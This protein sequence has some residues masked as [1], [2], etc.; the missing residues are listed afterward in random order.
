MGQ[1]AIKDTGYANTSA[2][3][4]QETITNSG[5]AVTFNGAKLTYSR[6][7]SL[8]N[9]PNPSRYEDSE[10][11]YITQLNPTLTLSGVVPQNASAYETLIKNIDDLCITKGLKL[12]YYTDSA[13][14][15][16]NIP[17]A[18]GATAYGSLQVNGV[19]KCLLVRV[20]NWSI[21]EEPTKN[22]A[23]YN[24]TI[25]ITNEIGVS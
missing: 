4:T 5:T 9:A 3:G 24:I 11:N 10:I 18:L 19:I 1:Y 15:Y 16:K 13:D 2:A 23:R 25:E 17:A 14:G 21:S 6:N 22:L 8:D 12:L 20:K 7:V